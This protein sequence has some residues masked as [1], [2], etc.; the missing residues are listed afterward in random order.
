MKTLLFVDPHARSTRKTVEYRSG[1]DTDIVDLTVTVT[2]ALQDN[3]EMTKY[4]QA[5]F[6]FRLTYPNI[7]VQSTHNI[8]Y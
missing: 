8:G 5:M 7:H 4:R 2:L 3:V 1:N 6:K